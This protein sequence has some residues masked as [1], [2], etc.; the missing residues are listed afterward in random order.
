[1]ERY[2]RSSAPTV[3]PSGFLILPKIKL[4]DQWICV[5]ISVPMGKGE[6]CFEWSWR[7]GRAIKFRYKYSIPS[8]VSAR[9]TVGMWNGD[10]KCGIG[11]IKGVAVK[12]GHVYTPACS[13]PD[14]LYCTHEWHFAHSRL[15]FPHKPQTHSSSPLQTTLW[16]R[17]CAPGLSPWQQATEWEPLMKWTL[18]KILSQSRD[19]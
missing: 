3:Q 8:K 7:R 12:V 1:M 19:K 13:E 9:H 5:Q 17:A 6:K 10:N 4:P 18:L 2:E 16:H 14:R 15:W 11:T